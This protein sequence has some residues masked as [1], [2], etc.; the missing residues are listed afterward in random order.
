MF[1]GP[2]R[3]QPVQA[4]QG[5]FDAPIVADP[6]NPRNLIVGSDYTKCPYPANSAYNLSFDG[7]SNWSDQ[8]CMDS[9]FYEGN[10]YYPSGGPILGYDLNGV[11]YV[12]GD[13]GSVGETNLVFEGFQKSSDG[14]N[15]TAPAAMLVYPNY[16]PFYCWMAVDDNVVSPYAN[17]V[18][19]SCVIDDVGPPAA[20]VPGIVVSHSND[21]GASWHQSNAAPP[22]GPSLDSYTTTSVGRDGTVYLSMAGLHTEQ[23]M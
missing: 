10:E 12:G 17:T 7:G 16:A 5:G 3:Y 18:Y 13:Y 4:T 15:W 20:S 8:F 21:G 2:V 9:V 14:V 6:T 11:A 22:Q 19:A 23:R 1:P